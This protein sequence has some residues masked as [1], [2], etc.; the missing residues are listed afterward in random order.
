[1]ALVGLNV[2]CQ[3][4]AS[5]AKSVGLSVRVHCMKPNCVC[6]SVRLFH[7]VVGVLLSNKK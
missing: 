5:Q 7:L 6:L 3:E 4:V 2:R 1:M